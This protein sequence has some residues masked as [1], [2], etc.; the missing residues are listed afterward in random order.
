MYVNVYELLFQ[1]LDFITDYVRRTRECNVFTGVCTPGNEGGGVGYILSKSCPDGPCSGPVWGKLVGY[2]L[3]SQVL[4][5]GGTYGLFTLSVS[6][7]P[8]LGPEKMGC[9][10]LYRTFHIAQGPE[11]H[12][13]LLCWSW[14]QC[15]FRSQSKPV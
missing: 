8:E 15:Q 10:R 6:R 7:T 3:S 1:R 9:M 13:F 2:I 12:C 14:S 5:R 11:P 4:S